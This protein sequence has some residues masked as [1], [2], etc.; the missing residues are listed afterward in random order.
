[1]YS[2]KNLKTSISF[3]MQSKE[4]RYNTHRIVRYII[5]REAAEH[6]I[7]LSIILPPQ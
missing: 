2:F 4:N 1:M 5:M 7:V 6:L 3:V